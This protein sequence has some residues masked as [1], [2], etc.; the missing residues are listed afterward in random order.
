M[1]NED[2]KPIMDV[3]HGNI[4]TDCENKYRNKN[5][6][7]LLEKIFSYREICIIEESLKHMRDKL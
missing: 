6:L 2:I 3:L 4:N 7:L 1:F 5:R